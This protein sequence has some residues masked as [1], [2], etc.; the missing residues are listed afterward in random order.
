MTV[1]IKIWEVTY[2]VYFTAQ[3][4]TVQCRERFLKIVNK[5]K[6]TLPKESISQ[7]KLCRFPRKVYPQDSGDGFKNLLR[8]RSKKTSTKSRPTYI[9]RQFRNGIEFE[10][11]YV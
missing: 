7:E 6:R 5:Y 4:W 10:K 9:G 8:I 2:C 1:G 3:R 11:H